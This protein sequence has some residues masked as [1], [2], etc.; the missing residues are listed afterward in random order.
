MPRYDDRYSSND[1][2]GGARLCVG[3]LSSRTRERDLEHL[4]SKYGS[5]AFDKVAN[6]QGIW[7]R[8]VQLPWDGA[9]HL[10]INLQMNYWH[11]L[12]ANIR[13]CQEP[14][15]DHMSALAINGRKTAQFNNLKDSNGDNTIGDALNVLVSDTDTTPIKRVFVFLLPTN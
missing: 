4:F 2:Y 14:L 15:F 8:D 11:S 6:L 9:P 5:S 3:H 10:N 12:P 13:E 7:S 1:R